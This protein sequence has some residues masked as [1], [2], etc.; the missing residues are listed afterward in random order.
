MFQEAETIL[1]DLPPSSLPSDITVRRRIL[2]GRILCR[3]GKPAE[4]RAA[5]D[6]AER[7]L[8]SSESELRAELAFARGRCAISIDSAS[9]RNYYQQSAD[10]AHGVDGFIEARGLL[11]VGF[12][13]LEH[14]DYRQSI[15]TLQKILSITDSPLLL[16]KTN[17]NL[18]ECYAELGDWRQS[19][20]YAQQSEKVAE[21][22]K[23][24]SDKEK[25]LIDLGRAH[26]VLG[27][28]S[29]AEPYFAQALGIA[30]S[31]KDTE[32][33]SRCLNDLTQLALR[34]HDL[35]AAERYWKEESALPLG[36]ERRTYLSFDAAE[37]ALERK[38]LS[39][40]EHLFKEIL[41]AKPKDSLRLTTERELGNVYWRQQRTIQADREFRDA[42]FDAEAVIAQL[43]PQ[44]Q[45]S[46]LDEDPFYDSYVR[47]LA[48]QGKQAD[49][50]KFAERGRA[51]ILAQALRD[52]Q[53]GQSTFN[54]P[55][56]Q[57]VLRHRNQ[58]ALAYSLTDQESFLWVIAPTA[59]PR[60]FRLPSHE[61]ISDQI[62]AYNG[63]VV[64]HPR[65]IQDSP[66]GQELY[67]TLVRP[68]ES[69]IPRGSH[70][71]II[72]SKILSEINFEALIVPGEHPHYWI[73]DVE[74]ETAS[75]L[76]L[77]THS[78]PSGT[79]YTQKKEL[80]L[81][82]AP[83]E[84]D[85]SLPVLQHATEEIERI[86]SHFPADQETIISGPAAIPQAYRA[87]K[88]GDFR[89]VHIDAHS[90]PSDISPLDSFVALSPAAGNA[91]K[92]YARE[93][94]ATR[95]HADLVTISACYSAGSRWY[96]GEG[97]VGLG[98]AFLRAGAHQVVASLWAVDDAS[99][100]AL[101]DDFY[102]ELSQG[103]P[104]AQA[105]RDAK[106]NMLHYGGQRSRPYYWAS[107]QLYTGS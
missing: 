76:A 93:I 54:L 45:M 103:K 84:A 25:W 55:V 42:I 98:W 52:V 11:D 35:N 106:L 31:Q 15:D 12:L 16:E 48:D 5:L 53:P 29:R 33:V 22:I 83:T 68:A 6:E 26:F 1:A 2:Q 90:V 27:E 58:I 51:Q 99:T 57:A 47:F 63:E 89:L 7:L 37:I 50:L 81:L 88:P 44:Y 87:N 96:M 102:R 101:M 43:P 64:K 75:S 56:L 91:Y 71:V 32:A 69:L 85:P 77:L 105:L 41:K 100:P 62:D 74:V 19:I 80:F 78:H 21:Q 23:N 70:V 8:H 94:E 95:L 24:V 17:G 61:T 14:R 3:V 9:A 97:I 13:L 20:A 18:A 28:Y 59:Q 34:R 65:S 36:S 72:P 66:A 46:F 82:G 49:A 107:L 10:L 38:D 73:E 39:Q 104:A 86:R 92:L 30:N 40:A 67:K 60:L 79:G 4:S